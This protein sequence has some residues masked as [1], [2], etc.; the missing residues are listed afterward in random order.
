MNIN[1]LVTQF[2]AFRRT[3]GE[4]EQDGSQCQRNRERLF[5]DDKSP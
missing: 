5:S 1:E 4:R 2:V 3:L